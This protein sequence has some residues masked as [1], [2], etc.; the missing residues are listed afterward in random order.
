MIALQRT[1]LLSGKVNIMNLPTTQKK[2]DEWDMNSRSLPFI[3][4]YFPELTAEQREFILTGS[5][6]EE[7]NRA[8][9]EEDE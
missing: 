9:P 8:F 6:P 1:S 3:Q 5:T 2:I 4:D 7:W